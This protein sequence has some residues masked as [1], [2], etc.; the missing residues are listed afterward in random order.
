M[1]KELIE[2]FW[3]FIVIGATL[4]GGGYAMIPVVERELIKKR[5]WVEMDEVLD[6]FTIAQITPGII[7]VNVATF[8]GYKRKGIAGGIIA[9]LGIILPGTCL[10]LIISVFL[11]RFSDYE[12]VRH[13]FT[14]IR[15]AVCALILNTVIKISKNVIRGLKGIIIF[16]CAFILSGIFG[17]SPVFIIFGAGLAGFLFFRNTEEGKK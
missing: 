13:I 16:I 7:A 5:R 6:Y 2:L 1:I 12:M 17:I 8:V 9:T 3:S 11:K 15:I 14:G 4:F 10:M